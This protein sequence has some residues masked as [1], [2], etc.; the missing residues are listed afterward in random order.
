MAIIKSINLT[1]ETY[2]R[3]SEEFQV[4]LNA[5]D[6]A[7][8][9]TSDKTDRIT[10]NLDP[11]QV[12]ENLIPLLAHRMGFVY[13][14]RFQPQFNRLVLYHFPS[15]IYNR[16]SRTG[17]TIGALTN[18]AS[19]GLDNMDA[20]SDREFQYFIDNFRNAYS[21]GVEVVD[22]NT[23]GVAYNGID[24]NAD[25]KLTVKSD[26]VNFEAEMRAR[27]ITEDRLDETTLP[28]NAVAVSVN[29]DALL[30]DSQ[31]RVRFVRNEPYY[32]NVVYFSEVVP[33]DACLEYVR[34]LGLYLFQQAGVKLSAHNRILIHPSLGDQLADNTRINPNEKFSPSIYGGI[35]DYNRPD[36]ST[37]QQYAAHPFAGL[38]PQNIEL[39]RLSG[40]GAD[41]LNP[42]TNNSRPTH[43]IPLNDGT[44]TTNPATWTDAGQPPLRDELNHPL[45]QSSDNAGFQQWLEDNAANIAQEIG[46]DDNGKP[47]YDT[48]QFVS[49]T[50]LSH[51]ME[52]G[53]TAIRVVSIFQF[54]IG[55]QISFRRDGN[56]TDGTNLRTITD[57]NKASSIIILNKA[58]EAKW[59]LTL[60]VGT[61]IFTVFENTVGGQT[62]YRENRRRSFSTEASVFKNENAEVVSTTNVPRKEVI[63][64]LMSTSSTQALFKRIFP[65]PRGTLIPNH[66]RKKFWSRN[67]TNIDPDQ[68]SNPNKRPLDPSQPHQGNPDLANYN[69]Y[70]LPPEYDAGYNTLYSFQLSNNEHTVKRLMPKIFELGYLPTH[71]RNKTGNPSPITVDWMSGD[72]QE[73]VRMFNLQYADERLTAEELPSALEESAGQTLQ[74]NLLRGKIRFGDD[75]GTGNALLTGTPEYLNV[76]NDAWALAPGVNPTLENVPKVDAEN[77]ITDGLK[78]TSIPKDKQKPTGNED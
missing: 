62:T 53:A 4:F 54:R 36:F 52:S 37:L 42:Q 35:G 34:P 43:S 57:I 67:S 38:N 68:N 39:P 74:L 10:D 19:L 77:T 14:W 20:V 64:E 61:A 71:T 3:E 47:I 26:A 73:K 28:N 49:P 72:K 8:S 40:S 76:G 60:P 12:Q 29:S 78:V 5:I 66:N 45:Y 50:T 23:G 24:H 70:V 13:D 75:N 55:D 16:G 15:M 51:R 32:I 59:E 65:S 46:W 69:P 6:Q 30:K 21:R 56:T 63:R 1:P 44:D 31:G 58:G 22:E 11:L 25:P 33:T 17:V 7:F 48:E 18:L 41:G 9:E 2:W 27:A